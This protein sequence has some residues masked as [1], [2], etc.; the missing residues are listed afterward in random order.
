MCRQAAIFSEQE[1]GAAGRTA[2]AGKAPDGGATAL[3]VE[4]QGPDASVRLWTVWLATLSL[5]LLWTSGQAR[6]GEISPR[7]IARHALA[8][9]SRQVVTAPALMEQLR[10]GAG[11]TLV[12][13]RPAGE[14][15]ALHIPGAIHLPLHFIKTKAHLR[16]SPL[17]LVEQGL[18]VH[19]LSPVCRDL[20]RRGFSARILEG[21]LN[22]WHRHGGPLTGDPARRMDLCRISPADFFQ[23]KNYPGRLV[24]HLSLEEDD[25]LKELMPYAVHLSVN[26]DAA[27]GIFRLKKIA[28]A[29]GVAGE[30]A[31]LVVNQTGRNDRR[32]EDLFRRAGLNNLFY[33]Q[34][35]AAAYRRY[36]EGLT[37]A[38]QPR[39]QRL[40]S[41]DPCPA[42]AENGKEKSQ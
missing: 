32:L 29:H 5:W 8:V 21:G 15:E 42:C 24:L 10:R 23:E 26:G 9:E 39:N 4:G 12:D 18:A 7:L 25:S 37:L 1:R 31:V 33:L 11:I 38:W 41:A 28:S 13:V 2:L 36:L 20:N 34:G 40:V 16:K 30:S 14:F 22:A 3:S 17:V 19:R 27:D 35:G 6:A